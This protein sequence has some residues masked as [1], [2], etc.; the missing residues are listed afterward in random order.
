MKLAILQLM[1]DR[2][3]KKSL[4][5]TSQLPVASWYDYL[6]EPTLADAILDRVVHSSHRIDLKGA[7]LR[8]K[9][10]ET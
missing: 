2:Y 3:A 1:E 6:E 7:T 9:K 4:I 10:K 8:D 5:I